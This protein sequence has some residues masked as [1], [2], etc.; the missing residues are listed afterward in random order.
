VLTKPNLLIGLFFLAGAGAL[1]A[2]G[3]SQ[4]LVS[5]ASASSRVA[6]T[7]VFSQNQVPLWK[8]RQLLS[9]IYGIGGRRYGQNNLSNI[10]Y[11]V[12]IAM[13]NR[14]L[15][16]LFSGYY[17]QSFNSTQTWN[18][19]IDLVAPSSPL[20]SPNSAYT[21]QPLL[22]E[23]ALD[24]GH[25]H[26]DFAHEFDDGKNDGWPF[27]PG[28][29]SGWVG[30]DTFSYVPTS[31]TVPYAQMVKAYGFADH[32]FQANEGPSF[33]AHQYLISGQSGGYAGGPFPEFSIAENPLDN[34]P[35]GYYPFSGPNDLPYCGSTDEANTINMAGSYESQENDGANPT[36]PPCYT[37]QYTTIFDNLAP[38]VTPPAFTWE[39]IAHSSTSLWAAPM[40]VARYANYNNSGQPIPNFQ[41]DVDA[42]NFV[43]QTVPT[44]QLAALTYLTPCTKESDHPGSGTNTGPQWVAWVVDA[45]GNSKVWDQTAIFVVWDDWG[46]WYDHESALQGPY[47]NP[48]HNPSDPYE[49][50]YRVPLI[51]ISPYTIPGTVDKTPRSDSSILDFVEWNFG[52]GSLGTDDTAGNNTD[53]LGSLFNSSIALPFTP[54]STNFP[55]SQQRTSMKSGQCPSP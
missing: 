26:G 37:S 3:S 27:D 45:I 16:N 9:T 18:Q 53:H 2:I 32:V 44:G 35:L 12:V 17:G 49:W 23:S 19:K 40:A 28:S 15:D 21:L 4:P 39:Y 6:P 25:T 1:V 38:V 8:Q 14:S 47:P 30:T 33:P 55:T 10:K 52:A 31:E 43:T 22:L 51:A 7:A 54:I 48:Y 34:S 29:G 20:P 11:V 42:Y 13:E 24:P 36:A 50:G 41:V 46:G 5:A